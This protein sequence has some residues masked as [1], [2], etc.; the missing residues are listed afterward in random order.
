MSPKPVEIYSGQY[1]F[2]ESDRENNL[3]LELDSQTE[4][5]RGIDLLFRSNSPSDQIYF[6]K[7]FAHKLEA[8]GWEIP[9]YAKSAFAAQTRIYD[10]RV[11]KNAQNSALGTVPVSVLYNV[12]L[13]EAIRRYSPGWRL[14]NDCELEGYWR[15]IMRAL[16]VEDW[17]NGR[18]E[19]V[20]DAQG[21]LVMQIHRDPASG[22]YKSI[23]SPLPP[24]SLRHALLW[25]PP[26]LQSDF[27]YLLGLP[28]VNV[29]NTQRFV[30]S[31]I[32]W[33][34]SNGKQKLSG[35][36]CPADKDAEHRGARS[37]TDAIISQCSSDVRDIGFPAF[38]ITTAIS[39][40]PILHTRFQNSCIVIMLY[41]RTA[42]KGLLVHIPTDDTTFGRQKHNYILGTTLD[43]A[44][45]MNDNTQDGE[46][47]L[48]LSDNHRFTA[49]GCF[50]KYPLEW[51]ASVFR[52]VYF[53]SSLD[54]D[55]D[56]TVLSTVVTLRAAVADADIAF[57]RYFPNA[58]IREAYS[59][60]LGIDVGVSSWLD[61]KNGSIYITNKW[62]HSN[63]LQN[64]QLFTSFRQPIK[65]EVW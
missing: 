24:V 37:A 65:E 53:R 27:E 18:D 58:N 19:E 7:Y 15:C 47:A 6:Q 41:D 63:D 54:K 4:V 55:V 12:D 11:A 1:Y 9:A 32:D 62:G 38:G 22:N 44:C 35:P 10:D 51:Y 16:H 3:N 36:I 29:E 31:R 43:Y 30:R 5:T 50:G 61:T 56:V 40:N 39:S 57:R 60:D 26:Y 59:S 46:N 49:R 33:E 48:G 64:A 21:H 23:S 20:L 34:E 45:L 42:K 28:A 14:K 8:A 17:S 13:G 25:L 2:Y 52:N